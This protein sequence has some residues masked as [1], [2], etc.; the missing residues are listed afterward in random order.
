MICQS[1][2]SNAKATNLTAPRPPLRPY[3]PSSLRPSVPPS[4]RP[5]VPPSLRP[6]VPPSLFQSHSH[7]SHFLRL[8]SIPIRPRLGV[9]AVQ[10]FCVST[11]HLLRHPTW[12]SQLPR[13]GDCRSMSL[14]AAQNALGP[15]AVPRPT[16][17]SPH[18][19]LPGRPEADRST[20]Y[21]F[22]LKHLHAC[23]RRPRAPNSEKSEFSQ[24]SA[25]QNEVSHDYC[26]RNR[27]R[28]GGSRT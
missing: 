5:F 14:N 26:P 4:L 17:P 10:R 1:T 25:L 8:A 28:Y 11:R 15:P 20:G 27:T 23:E 13:A 22:R 16:Q 19:P 12:H 24:K 2:P 18:S 6:F 3:V 9:L 21:P 7:R